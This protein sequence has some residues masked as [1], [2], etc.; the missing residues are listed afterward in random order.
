MAGT[1]ALTC[2]MCLQDSTDMLLAG[3]VYR[4]SQPK[5]K[6][7]LK[8]FRTW[9]GRVLQG[10]QTEKDKAFRGE[11]IA[12]EGCAHGV[13]G[14]AQLQSGTCNDA[15][16]LASHALI[17]ALMTLWAIACAYASGQQSACK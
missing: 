12:S 7:K 8:S 9:L 1:D 10:H 3:A 4:C 2:A 15:L 16:T 14:S 5:F 17:G 11:V 13:C 6:F